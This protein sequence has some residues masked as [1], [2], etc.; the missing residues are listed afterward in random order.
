MKKKWILCGLLSSFAASA[1]VDNSQA[2]RVQPYLQNPANDAMTIMWLSN[3]NEP[4]ELTVWKNNTTKEYIS[5]PTEVKELSYFP[6]EIEKYRDQLPNINAPYIHNVRLLNLDSG[7]KYQYSVTQNGT[8][9]TSTFTTPSKEDNV[10]FIVYSDSET[11]PESTGKT[12]RW[13]EPFGDF[14]RQYIVDQTVGYQ[15]NL[16][17]IAERNPNFIAIAGD[18]VESGN[19]Q[20][21]WDEFWRHNA[22]ELGN[23]ASQAPLLP[24]LGN[25]E[26][27][28]GPDG[29][30]KEYVEEFSAQAIARYQAYFDVPD[31][32]SKRAV[33]KDRYY[34][35]DYGPITYISIDTSDGKKDKSAQDTNWRLT[36]INAPDFNPG[37]EQ[38]QWLE[39][40]LA[41][42]Q[43]Q[44]QF[45]F[46]QFHHIPYSVGP[47]GFPTGS[48]GFENGQDNQ[49][50]VPVR[51]LTPLFKKYDVKAVFAGHDEMYEHSVVDGINFY[52]I[53]IGGDGLRGPYFGKD[54]KYDVKLDNPHQVFLAHLDSPEVWKGKQL[55][56]GGKHYGH[57]EVNVTKNSAGDW[58]AEISPVYVFPLM[59]KS[60]NITGWERRVYDDVVKLKR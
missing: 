37:S 23:V 3:D 31:N 34:R 35:V 21:D 15:Q 39:K 12:R 1:T 13:S 9:F 53:G 48:G 58:T 18:L 54:G 51:I 30:K 44:S 46:V 36:G 20:R 57:L 52:D 25:H 19:E 38:Y 50:G 33:F 28:P 42:A 6:T 16:K 40:Q 29:G 27:Y 22:G 59:D 14:N 26:N 17:V 41:D 60:G 45:T 7:T 24:A 47:H 10:R 43:K 55:V 5:A 11:E 49:S 32:G 56:S 8:V 4:G 2:F